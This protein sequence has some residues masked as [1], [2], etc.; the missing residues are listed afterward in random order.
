MRRGRRAPPAQH[1]S[2]TSSVDALAAGPA[3]SALSCS[4]TVVPA[5]PASRWS[6]LYGTS[7][8]LASAICASRHWLEFVRFRQTSVVLI[9]LAA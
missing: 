4:G 6:N 7:N 3:I 2:L 8:L 9:E 5:S 1:S